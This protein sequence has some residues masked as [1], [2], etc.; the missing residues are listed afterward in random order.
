[1]DILNYIAPF[2]RLLS[3]PQLGQLNVSVTGLCFGPDVSLC[4]ALSLLK[5]HWKCV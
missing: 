4:W 1:M 5:E 3:F 2:F